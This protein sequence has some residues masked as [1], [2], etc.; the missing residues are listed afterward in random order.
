MKTLLFLLTLLFAI[1]ATITVQA[2]SN[3]PLYEGSRVSSVWEQVSSDEY[4]LPK[5][6]IS[7]V[8]LGGWIKSKIKNSAKRTLA[9]GS[10]LLPQFRKLAHPNGVCLLGTWKISKENPYS[11]YFKNGSVAKIIA[12]ASTAMSNTKAGDYRGFGM[13]GKLYPTTDKFH[14]NKLK[15]GNFFV[16]DDLGG[17][18]AKHYTDV[19][20]INE[21]AV[22]KNPS[23]FSHLLYALK[24]ASTFGKADSNPGIRQ[25]YQ[26]SE[27]GE[28]SKNIITPKWINIRAVKGQTVNEADFRNEL[29]VS[30]YKNDLKFEILVA[31]TAT[32]GVKNWISIG[33]INFNESVVSNSCDHRLHFN[34][35]KWK[36]NLKHK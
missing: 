36:N 13:A 2:S 30:N 35:P 29:N 25:V 26:I 19:E 20:L 1:T 31:S 21:P 11:G 5:N 4:Q 3:K 14:E 8:S 27:L 17:T 16:A 24:L 10:D 12:R 32:K 18:K 22:S 34:H 6:K 28:S 7:L 15:T 23:F 33:Q 9:D